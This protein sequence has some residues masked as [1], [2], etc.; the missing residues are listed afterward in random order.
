MKT[1]NIKRIATDSSFRTLRDIVDNEA[2]FGK[3]WDG[4]VLPG[5]SLD[6]VFTL[7]DFDGFEAVCV[8][9]GVEKISSPNADVMVVRYE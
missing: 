6:I 5:Y 3:K 1:M 4:F 2:E 8:G 9:S 7:V